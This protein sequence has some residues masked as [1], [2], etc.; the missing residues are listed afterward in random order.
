MKLM[1]TL[2]LVGFLAVTL[3]MIG[4]KK[5]ENPTPPNAAPNV[6]PEMNAAPMPRGIPP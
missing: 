1:L 4:C 5:E 6:A 2:V 3:G